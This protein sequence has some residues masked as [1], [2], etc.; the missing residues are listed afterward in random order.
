MRLFLSFLLIGALLMV[1]QGALAMWLPPPF[2][3][4]L[5]L[6]VVICLGLGWPTLTTGLLLVGLLGFGADLLS[7]SLMGQQ[8]LLRIFA[9]L[10][11]YVASRQFNLQGALPLMVFTAGLSFVYGVA[12]QG[13]S[14]FFIGA[15]SVQGMGWWAD[16]VWH[17][18]VNALVVPLIFALCKRVFV[19]VI[20][21]DAIDH[22]L[23]LESGRGVG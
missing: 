18:G 9:F 4:D 14:F 20:G 19:W 10:G 3:P 16:N 22:A 2:C 15:V 6:L 23:K 12:L 11:A 21:E 1:M 7:N 8:A 17:A 13:L 5:G